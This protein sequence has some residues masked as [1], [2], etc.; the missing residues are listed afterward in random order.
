MKII[1]WLISAARIVVMIATMLVMVLIVGDVFLR[2]I[3]NSPILGV[4][5]YSQLLMVVLLLASATA[6]QDDSHI[7]I[8]ILYKKF[9]PKVQAVCDIITLTLS[10][11][12]A[13][14]IATQSFSQGLT[15]SR[16]GMRFVTIGIPR[17]PFFFLFSA[18]LLLLCVAIVVL[19]INAVKRLIDECR[20]G[21]EFEGNE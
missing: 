14:L 9:P 13:M 15:A 7:K 19:I 2:W 4:V 11:G 5:E 17:S 1:N 21:K 18:G 12:T 20:R 6:A 3:F 8:D 16:F 10:F